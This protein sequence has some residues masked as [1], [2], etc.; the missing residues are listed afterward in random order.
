VADWLGDDVPVID[1]DGVIVTVAVP[2]WEVVPDCVVVIDG[3]C[4]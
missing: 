2:D 4:V 1:C 3:D